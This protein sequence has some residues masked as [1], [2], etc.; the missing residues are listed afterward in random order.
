MNAPVTPSI[1]AMAATRVFSIALGSLPLEEFRTLRNEQNFCLSM[2]EDF[3]PFM[4][5][6]PDR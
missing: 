5:E 2:V 6:V 4:V 1:E 3:C